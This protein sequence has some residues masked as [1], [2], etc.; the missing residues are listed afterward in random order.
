MGDKDRG[1]GR[2]EGLL[3]FRAGV[4]RDVL[5]ISEGFVPVTLGFLNG[6]AAVIRETGRVFEVLGK[7]VVKTKRVVVDEDS[8]LTRV[9]HLIVTAVFV[10]AASAIRQESVVLTC[11]VAPRF[12]IGDGMFA[13]VAAVSSVLSAGACKARFVVGHFSEGKDLTHTG[14]EWDGDRD[15]VEVGLQ[16]VLLTRLRAWDCKVESALQVARTRVDG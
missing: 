14:C 4:D 11:C 13:T 16:K 12:L 9:F 8:R 2:K 6:K 10:V 5:V 1:G 7:S 3:V 15:C